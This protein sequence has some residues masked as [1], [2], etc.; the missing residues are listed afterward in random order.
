MTPFEMEQLHDKCSSRWHAM[1]DAEQQAWDGKAEAAHL[2][3]IAAPPADRALVERQEPPVFEP[4]EAADGGE[5]YPIPVEAI[6]D[7]RRSVRK[8]EQ[9]RLAFDDPAPSVGVAPI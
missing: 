9:R 4:W 3:A 1:G 8:A 7:D 6:A 2:L 5:A